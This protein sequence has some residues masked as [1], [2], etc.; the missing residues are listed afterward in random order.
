[1]DGM[2]STSRLI[3][4]LGGMSWES[5][6]LYYRGLN[7]RVQKKLG[8][9]HNARSILIT[10]DYEELLSLASAGRWEE[11]G[12]V[13]HD[14]ARR[15]T[16]AG[17]EFL[18]IT[19]TTGHAVAGRVETGLGVPLLHLADPTAEAI[20]QAGLSRVG[21][22]GTRFTMEMDFFTARLRDR[23]GLEVLVPDAA[24]RAA[25]HR[26]IVEEL[27]L[28]IVRASSK[29]VVQAISDALVRKGAEGIIVGCTELP[30]LL[31]KDDYPAPTFDTLQLHMDAAADAALSET[32]CS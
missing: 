13:L 26:I 16:T 32:L 23:H 22:L 18:L 30:M 31:D 17:A 8:K 1:M 14:A 3:G 10:L 29:Q 20:R 6:A 19:A 9:H 27:T 21:L 5:S 24:E 12:D 11:V 25:L 28:G 4:L 15:V 2:R 7:E